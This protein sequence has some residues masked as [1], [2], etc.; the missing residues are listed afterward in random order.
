M[1]IDCTKYH[2]EVYDIDPLVCSR[3]TFEFLFG[4]KIGSN[5]ECSASG[6]DGALKCMSHYDHPRAPHSPWLEGILR[7]L[8]GSDADELNRNMEFRRFLAS[9][10]MQ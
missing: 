4:Q 2:F 5:G 1:H 8:C 10:S 9:N 3:A 6:L 7:A